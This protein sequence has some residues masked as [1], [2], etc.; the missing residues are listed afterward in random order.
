MTQAA[1][2]PNLA[3][4]IVDLCGYSSQAI[5]KA[6]AVIDEKEA[7]DVKSA[8]LIP[9]VAQA[10]AD[11]KHILPDEVKE[12][13]EMLKDPAMALEILGKVASH[14]TKSDGDQHRLGQPAGTEKSAGA[15]YN[16]LT[17]PHVGA[18]TTMI[19][20]SDLAFSRGLG[21]PDPVAE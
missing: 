20:E 5:E 13:E 11:N 3:Q 19:K 14:K 16:S 1:T 15:K 7:Q 2:Q 10:L 4:D 8:A 21:L 17:S 9:Q 18:R 6:S 12:A